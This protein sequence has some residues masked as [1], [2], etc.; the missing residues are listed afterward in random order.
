MNYDN[1]YLAITCEENPF[2][3]QKKLKYISIHKSKWIK[4]T[5]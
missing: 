2:V 3:F 5:N 1:I 4:L